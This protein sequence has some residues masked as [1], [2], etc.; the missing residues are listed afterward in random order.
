MENMKD[1][2]WDFALV[3]RQK[4]QAEIFRNRLREEGIELKTPVELIKVVLDSA[5]EGVFSVSV[6][7]KD[8]VSGATSMIKCKYLIGADGRRSFIRR[9]LDIPFDGSTTEGKWVGIDGMVE[10]GTPKSRSYGAIESKIHGNVLWPPWIMV[11]QESDSLS[12]QKDRRDTQN[13]MRLQ[14]FRKRSNP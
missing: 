11:P 1:T 6:I 13:S 10:S 14:R 8:G 9:T 2:A 7:L 4:Y 12:R 3:L 5:A